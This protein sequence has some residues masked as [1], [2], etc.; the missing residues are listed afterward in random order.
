MPINGTNGNDNILGTLA[1]DIINAGNGNDIVDASDGNDTVNA[2]NGNDTVSGGIGNDMLNGGSGNDWLDGGQGNDTLD[3]GNGEDTLYGGEGNDMLSGGNGNDIMNGGAGNDHLLGG[4]GKDIAI[5]VAS[6]NIGS[7][8]IYEGGNGND[9][10]RL[11]LTGAEWA[12]SDIRSSITDYQGALDGGDYSPFH[13]AGFDLT[14][15]GFENLELFVDGVLVDPH[16][17]PLVID[18]EDTDYAPLPEPYAGFS[19]DS[20]NSPY[21]NDDS[22]DI[23]GGNPNIYTMPSDNELGWNGFAGQSSTMSQT[24]GANFDLVSLELIDDNIIGTEANQL[25]IQGWDD[26]VLEQSMSIDLDQALTEYVLNWQDI[27][28]VTFDVTAGDY[29]GSGWWAMDNVTVAV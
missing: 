23:Y 22:A 4:N 5:Y 11:E 9:T 18:F 24:S 26:G 8:D 20:V 15:R 3:G 10:L 29:Y 21:A 1:A 27:D 14:A 12:Q 7:T 19:W 17:Q 25:L 16:K 28:T 2:G 13:F 6:E